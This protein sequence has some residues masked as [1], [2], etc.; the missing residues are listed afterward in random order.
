MT[1]QK[2]HPAGVKKAKTGTLEEA[3]TGLES[4][5]GA[6]DTIGK[7]LYVSHLFWL[8]KEAFWILLIS[9]LAI[10]FGLISVLLLLV[11]TYRRRDGGI[12]GKLYQEVGS[13]VLIGTT[14]LLWLI[15]NCI[16]MI[17]FFIY[18]VPDKYPGYAE[19]MLDMMECTGESCGKDIEVW[20]WI[21][22]I[23]FLA[24]FGIWCLSCGY[25]LREWLKPPKFVAQGYQFQ[26]C[27][28]EGGWIAF[29]VLKDFLWTFDKEGFPMAVAA[30]AIHFIVLIIA[31]VTNSS[32]TILWDGISDEEM[33]RI[34]DVFCGGKVDF[35]HLSYIFWSVSSLLWLLMENAYDEDLTLRYISGIICL[36]SVVLF[37]VGYPQAKKKAEALNLLYAE[38]QK[39][40]PEDAEKP[41]AAKETE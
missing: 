15:F 13:E 27:L 21:I 5:F 6:W 20:L 31:M 41:D 18:E 34:M 9:P 30:W 33:D 14:Q 2:V 32:G 24:A 25:L 8:L 36:V 39:L 7:L 23:G 4:G 28:L 26:T 10:A 29:W 1:E 19:D 16:L 12:S 35:I 3:K 37:I 40:P 22:R 38:F 11:V 17:I